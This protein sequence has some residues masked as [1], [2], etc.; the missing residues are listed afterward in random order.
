MIHCDESLAKQSLFPDRTEFPHVRNQVHELI[1]KLVTIHR[2]FLHSA[3]GNAIV[4]RKFR[5][6]MRS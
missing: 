2:D 4:G 1:E 3:N 5:F 6:K